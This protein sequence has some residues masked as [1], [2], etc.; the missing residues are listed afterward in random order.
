MCCLS[1][2]LLLFCL[3]TGLYEGL[4]IFY[5][6]TTLYACLGLLSLNSCSI[7]INFWL[8]TCLFFLSYMLCAP[9]SFYSHI[10]LS[11]LSLVKLNMP[12]FALLVCSSNVCT[13]HHLLSFVILVPFLISRYDNCCVFFYI[14]LAAII[15]LD[16]CWLLFLL[17]LLSRPYLTSFY[18]HPC[19]C[20]RWF[21]LVL[22]CNATFLF[23]YLL[24]ACSSLGKFLNH[25]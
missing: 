24:Y 1:P 11:W 25:N 19:S 14:W 2:V 16:L 21:F 18:I 12:G 22:F 6:C 13:L 9:I 8:V 3:Y 15:F 4:S 10:L 20:S 23:V 5:V 17:H 7:G